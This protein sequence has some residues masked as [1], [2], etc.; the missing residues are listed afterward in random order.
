MK[1]VYY[2]YITQ[3]YTVAFIRLRHQQSNTSQLR[4]GSLTVQSSSTKLHCSVNLVF[5]CDTGSITCPLRLHVVPP[6]VTMVLSLSFTLPSITSPVACLYTCTGIPLHSAPLSLV[7]KDL[8]AIGVL[9]LII[10]WLLEL[11]SMLHINLFSLK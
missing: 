8:G 1:F 5:P 10:H 2:R 9:L 3:T 6:E 11:H 7:S 4:E